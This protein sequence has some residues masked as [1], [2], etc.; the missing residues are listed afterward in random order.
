M[1][2][3]T[4][5]KRWYAECKNFAGAFC[6]CVFY[7]DKPTGIRTDGSKFEIQNVQEITPLMDRLTLAELYDYFNGVSDVATNKPKRII[8]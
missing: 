2:N 1:P 3:K 6:P 4:V 7:G 5:N 8:G